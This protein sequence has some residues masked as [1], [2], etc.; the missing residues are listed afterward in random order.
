MAGL[1]RFGLWGK[2]DVHPVIR[3]KWNTNSDEERVNRNGKE[4]VQRRADTHGG[5]ATGGGPDGSGDGTRSRS[6]HIYDLF[7][8]A[9]Y[10]GMEP[11]EAA[12]LHH[13]EDEN[14]RLKRFVADLSLDREM[15]KALLTINGLSS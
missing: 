5:E 6:E 8:E 15:L 11:S 9:K 14:S 12:R 1:G 13:L 3:P 2:Y 4:E 10:G 7:L